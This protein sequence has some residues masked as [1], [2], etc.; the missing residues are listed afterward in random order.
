M[1]EKPK[2]YEMIDSSLPVSLPG[3]WLAL[4]AFLL[5]LA[6]SIGVYAFLRPGLEQ[7]D[8]SSFS[9]SPT[10]DEPEIKNEPAKGEVK[11]DETITPNSSLS[12]V[13]SL[14]V[15]EERSKAKDSIS[16]APKT[17]ELKSKPEM[18]ALKSPETVYFGFDDTQI[19]SSDQSKLRFFL[20]KLKG[21]KG[22][23]M[24]E[25]H[26]DAV[27]VVEYN[28]LLST[29]RAQEVAKL[30][31]KLESAGAQSD[32]AVKIKGFGE[33]RP[34]KASNSEEV[35]RLSRRVVIRFQPTS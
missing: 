25:G 8:S 6:G 13:A 3:K 23:L 11:A 18:D 35:R 17:E 9:T 1:P 34:A 33:S 29:T 30:I 27:G 2:S 14:G 26:S 19:S 15:V 4:L 5:I 24:V 20:A 12:Q 22:N 31:E 16:G 21:T 10:K 32:L 28:Q 7:S